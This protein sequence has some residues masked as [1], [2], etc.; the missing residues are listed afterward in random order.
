MFVAHGHIV[1]VLD[2]LHGKWIKHMTFEC[3]VDFMFRQQDEH[4]EFQVGVLLTDGTVKIINNHHTGMNQNQHG[5]N[6][7][8]SIPLHIKGNLVEVSQ[9]REDNKWTFILSDVD[10]EPILNCVYHNKL[11]D[12]TS[13]VPNLTV[14]QNII[15]LF[16]PMERT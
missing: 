16:S 5:M 9:D 7:D 2:G 15:F 12:V 14:E 13:S 4:G 6:V 8:E 1:S 11:Y 3:D 10:G